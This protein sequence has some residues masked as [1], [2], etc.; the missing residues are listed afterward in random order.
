VIRE[1]PADAAPALPPGAL[2][3]VLGADSVSTLLK[4][5]K[6]L[7]N[8]TEEQ[9]RALL[10]QVQAGQ[11]AQERQTALTQPSTDL[12]RAITQGYAAWERLI[13]SHVRLVVR[14]AQRHHSER[15]ALE[16]RVQAGLLGLTQAIAQCDGRLECD[17]LIFACRAVHRAIHEGL[18]ATRAIR[19]T[20]S[21]ERMTHAQR[22]LTASLGREP[23]VAEIA[24]H[25]GMRVST[26]MAALDAEAGMAS[27]DA[28]LRADEPVTL[29][30]LVADTQALTPEALLLAREAVQERRKALGG[31]LAT[32]EPEA[33]RVLALRF[34]LEGEARG[35][36]EV[37]RAMGWSVP[38]VQKV[39]AGALAALRAGKGAGSG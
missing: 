30:D 16:E 3:A 5:V 2:D 32:L 22:E 35:V 4:V 20:R 24:S 15:V 23:T 10:A 34:G 38:Q 21:Q 39:E 25:A 6:P 17:F 7:P 36:T 9:A 8:L 27:L 11:A 37:A 19:R 33:R 31:A 26:V 28:P 14:F 18:E 29:A 1:A 12:A 13:L